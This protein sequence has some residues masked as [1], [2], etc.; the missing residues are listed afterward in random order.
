[1]NSIRTTI[2]CLCLFGATAFPQAQVDVTF[3]YSPPAGTSGPY[4]VVGDFNGWSNS[5]L[6]L[7]YTG[8]NVYIRT[9]RL[10]VGGTAGSAIPGS[11]QYKFYYA[12]VTSWP[13]DPLNP[14]TNSSDNGNSVLYIKDPT[15]YHLLPN[16]VS[17][18]VRTATPTVSAYIFPAVGMTLDTSSIAVSVDGTTYTGIGTA[19][20]PATQWLS[21]KLPDALLSGSH[22]LRLTA[23]ANTDSVTFT[24]QAGFVQIT[25]LGNFETRK[26]QRLLYGIVEDPSVD[27]VR[28]VRNGTDT[29]A[30]AVTT[31]KFTVNMDLAPGLNEFRAVAVDSTQAIR[32]SDAVVYTRV[33]DTLPKARIS[34]TGNGSN[35]TFSAFPSIG[36]PHDTGATLLYEWKVPPGNPASLPGV[37]GSMAEQLSVAAPT[38]PGDYRV[39]LVVA[40]SGGSLDTTHAFFRVDANG[41]LVASS[42]ATVP[43]WVKKGLI[44]TIFFKSLTPQGTIAAALPYLPYIKSMG[45][46]IIWI[47]P[48]MENA[49]PINNGT[50]PGYNIKDLFKVAPE[51]GTNAEFKNFVAQAHALG[52]KIILDVTPNHTSFAHP[53]VTEARLFRENSPRWDFYVHSVIPHNSNGL[54]QSLTTDGFNFYSGFSDQLLNYNWNDIDA[55]AYMVNAYE[56]WI[57]EFDLDGYRLDVYWGP[58]RRANNGAGGENEMGIPLRQALKDVKSDI[59]LLAEDNGTGTGSEVIFADQGGGVDSGYDW[60]LYFDAIRNFAFSA[61]AVDV[62]HTKLHN[63]GYVPGPNASFLRFMENHDED[64]I[65][66]FYGSYE[67][68]KPVATAVLLAPGMPMIYGGQE[69]GHG[70][71]ITDFD[72]R[73]RG[74]IN[75]AAAGKSVLQAHYQRLAHIRSQVDAFSGQ[76]IVRLNSGNGLVYAYSRPGT[77]EDAV[78]VAN[79]SASA[80]SATVVI[81]TAALG[82]S[83][84]DGT[85][86]VVSDLFHDSTWTSSPS[87]GTFT[88]NVDLPAYGSAAFAVATSARTVS[89]PLVTSIGVRDIDDMFP[90]THALEPNFPNPFN[91]STEVIYRIA[92]RTDVSLKVYTIL[93]EEVGTLVQGTL[94]AGSYRATWNGTD[95]TGRALSSGTY[96]LRMI[97]GDQVHVRKMLLIR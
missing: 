38:T 22:T 69:V 53:F 79:M 58:H 75:W 55:R 29:V 80:V 52:L 1:M 61:G 56:W 10:N 89:V 92:Q 23:G 16:Q 6:P 14:R 34:I 84:S 39:R 81:P 66:Y 91:P 68:T 20:N 24:V 88:M 83:Y 40:T 82:G 51:Y 90:T 30:A 46:N 59:F 60:P 25:N 63:A 93:G 64:R 15:I 85:S 31:G 97:A 3:R 17:G 13:N 71:G 70:L 2:L 19:Y 73:R 27:S 5:T 33:V 18:I 11:I 94:D 78:V 77:T 47:L 35:V 96:L 41:T 12:G 67:K 42:S 86:Y 65:V 62:L 8:G 45:A 76:S 9:V 50:G 57:R 43:S 87:A 28:I 44:Y 48:V 21:F 26:T 37:D 95:E 74:V 4:Y 36:P 54:G 49:Y 7:S 72:V 32:V